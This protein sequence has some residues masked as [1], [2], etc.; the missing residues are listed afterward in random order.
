VLSVSYHVVYGL[1]RMVACEAI[2]G[3]DRALDRL[4][5]WVVVSQKQTQIDSCGGNYLELSGSRTGRAFL[6][7]A[8]YGTWMP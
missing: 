7:L 6:S 4:G 3:A 1:H 2:H 8:V 5:R